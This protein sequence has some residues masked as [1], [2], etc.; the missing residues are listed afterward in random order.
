MKKIYKA[1]SVMRYVWE[2]LSALMAPGGN[3]TKVGDNT[4]VN[5]VNIGLKVKFSALKIYSNF[6]F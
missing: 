2:K 4:I 3:Q 6:V 1:G 5:V